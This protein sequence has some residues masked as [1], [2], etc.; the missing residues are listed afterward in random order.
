[1]NETDL[2]RDAIAHW[3]T[4]K[5]ASK[6]KKKA[7]GGTRDA[8]LHG[9]TMDGFAVTIRDFLV[10]M[11]V[12][13][14]HVIAGGHL[15]KTPSILPSYFRPSK[16]WDV[17]VLSNSRFFPAKGDAGNQPTLYAAVEFKSQDK[18][19]GNNQNNRLEES[20]GNAHDFWTTY[21]QTG[22]ARQQPRPWLGYLF[23]GKYV[24]ASDSKAV[25]IR[26]P[27]FL[28]MQPFRGDGNDDLETFKGPSY[29]ERYKIFMKQSVGARLYDA[30]AFV[31]TDESIKASNPN[32]RIPLPEFGP[33]NFL[34]G[35]K[36]QILAHY[37]GAS[38]KPGSTA[39][40]I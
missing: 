31:V 24:P 6:K 8:N 1:M 5:K 15:S 23:V 11:G 19:I 16:N 18:S 36:A 27:H 7:Q 4:S 25:K 40:L 20:I 9:K 17:V 3:W 21:E 37:P 35:L 2:F 30:G 26:Q 29:A 22:F 34:R 38:V 32:H 13:P 12:R 28:A 39:G 33:A 10:E 14:E